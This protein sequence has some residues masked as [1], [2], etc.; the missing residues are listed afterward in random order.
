MHLKSEVLH[1]P[2]VSQEVAGHVSVSVVDERSQVQREQ[3]QV[4]LLHCVV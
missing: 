3:L 4:N 2:L 1:K